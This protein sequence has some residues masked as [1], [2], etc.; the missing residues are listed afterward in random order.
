MC[1]KAHGAAFGTF[2]HADADR[3]RWV[4]GLGSITR[5]R[6][7]PT[8]VRAFCSICGS[9]VPVVEAEDNDV[10]IPAGTLD[11]DPGVKPI[12]HIFSGSKAPWYDLTDDVEQFE[13]F[14]PRAWVTKVIGSSQ[15]GDT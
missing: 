7:S 11:D 13:E 4:A 5:Y 1:R 15:A 6:S 3:F 12:V 10:I 2:L 9:N 14:P 8:N